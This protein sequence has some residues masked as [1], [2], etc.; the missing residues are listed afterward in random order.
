MYFCSKKIYQ[1]QRRV[2]QEEK[3]KA[4]DLPSIPK[5]N[6]N[7][8]SINLGELGKEQKIQA[9]DCLA[10]KDCQVIFNSN[11]KIT[12]SVGAQPIWECEFCQA[13]NEVQLDDEEIPTVDVYDYILSPAVHNS[14]SNQDSTI[15][16]VLD[17]SGSM[18]TT[19]EV[20]GKLKL[21][22]MNTNT[23]ME[24][25]G[26]D[27][28]RDQFL[29]GQRRDV[30]YVS[31]L[32]CVQAAVAHQIELLHKD[33]PNTKV[34]LV[35]FNNE[36]T[37][38]GDASNSGSAV[39]TGDK[40]NDFD[41]LIEEGVKYQVTSPISKSKEA[42]VKKLY[43]VEE[44]GSTALGPAFIVALGMVKNVPGSKIV[45]ATDGLANTGVGALDSF[46]FTGINGPPF[47]V[48]AGNL[49]KEHGI[50]ANVIGIRG[51]NLNMNI[52]GKLA[53]ITQG[54][55]EIVDP[56][57]ITDTFSSIVDSK[58]VAT[59]VV[60]K[61]F[62]H[63]VFSF[64]ADELWKS[65]EV[66]SSIKLHAIRDIGTAYENTEITAEFAQ[67][68]E[69]ELEKLLGSKIEAEISEKS[70]SLPFQVQI[71]YTTLTGMKCL[72]VITKTK[73][74]TRDANEAEEDIDVAVFG[75]HNNAVQ[76]S[77]AQRGM[78]EEALQHAENVN[79]VMIKSV[80]SESD[81]AGYSNYAYDQ[82][83]FVNNL[84]SVQQQQ[85]MSFPSNAPIHVVRQ[86]QQQMMENN[87]ESANML[88]A[89]RNCRK[90]N[91]NWSS[92]RKY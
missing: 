24:G 85:Q 52:I 54:D 42:L 3:E 48:R 78:L 44:T 87:D 16:F 32:Q 23:N 34:G 26:D 72:R 59:N 22:G 75:M 9:G 82:D 7:I 14:Q 28:A 6:T 63:K 58:V 74:V 4:Q 2:E 41:A 49:C 29:P 64:P 67:K 84:K 5:V 38:I 79:Q 46:E 65:E 30:T 91:S 86:Q 55:T 83:N 70:S 81:K 20:V 62:L 18:C 88:Y 21:K 33:H 50:T 71:T 25:F 36:V 76:A 92:N 1:P 57:K 19:S 53:D 40:L 11:S 43:G 60:V 90:Q 69:E 31:R 66:K 80:N 27:R 68:G 51:D 39:I 17:I 56:L 15:I 89:Q 47:Y 73:E 12:M 61:L 10:C 35:C 77:Y 8:V 37:V 13:I 45:L